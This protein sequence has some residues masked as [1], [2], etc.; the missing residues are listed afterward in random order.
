MILFRV[1]LAV[2]VLVLSVYTVITISNEGLTLFESALADVAAM[3]WSGQFALDFVCYLLLSFV[4]VA[5]RHE[6]SPLGLFLALLASQL[7]IIFFASYLIVISI[8][9]DGDMRKVLLGEKR[10][11]A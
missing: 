11:L 6:F 9:C 2:M 1:L 8:R 4:W 3:G 5:W 10:A 7:G